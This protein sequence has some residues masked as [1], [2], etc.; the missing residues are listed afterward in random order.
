MS[1]REHER[2][3]VA[4]AGVELVGD[5]RYTGAPG[6]FAVV[7]VHGFGSHRGGE[8]AQAMEAACDRHGWTFA[9]FD[10]R[11]HGESGGALLDLRPSDLLDDLTAVRAFLGR[12]GIDRIALVGSSMGGWA[13]AWFARGRADAAACVMLAPALHFPRGRWE[14]LSDDQR[15]QWRATGR[16]SI[17]N[18]WL[19]VEVGYGLAEQHDRFPVGQ[20]ASDWNKPLLIFHGMRDFVIPY[21]SSVAFVELIPAAPVELRLLRKGDHRLTE[22]KDEIAEESCRFFE[23]YAE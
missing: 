4:G 23:C 12:R 21:A 19:N 7:W 8:K 10:F 18:E 11:G 20:L 6:P 13:T 16:L 15:E 14:N 22:F 3:R 1:V 17:V 9:A 2:V 5:L